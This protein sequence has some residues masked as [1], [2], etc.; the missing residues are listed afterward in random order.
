MEKPELVS[1]LENFADPEQLS[2]DLYF[3]FKTG[4]IYTQYSTQPNERL[5]NEIIE[6]FSKEIARYTDADNPYELYDIYDDNEHE[7][8]HLSF[9]SLDKNEIASAVFQ[10]DK[11]RV[12][13][14]TAEVGKLSEIYAFIIELSDGNNAIRI[15][16][17]SMP[18]HA[19][20][21]NKF[22]NFF[23]GEDNN[24]ELI[25]SDA[26]YFD[27]SMDILQFGQSVVII[28][29]KTYEVRFGF[30]NELTERARTSFDALIATGI[31]SHSADIQSKVEKLQKGEKK[32]LNNLMQNNLIMQ[33]PNHKA[34]ILRH[35]KKYVKHE[36]KIDEDGNIA[37]SSQR[38][39]KILIK[40]LNRDY[41]Q[42][43]I[44]RE[45]FDTN[46]KKLLRD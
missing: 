33:K 32:K 31:F 36:F 1:Y 15:Y 7:E 2:V 23:T 9:D 6:T 25:K 14:Y 5:R 38:D 41:N 37:L 3:V 44:T 26:I 39:L 17:Q 12:E 10:F 45:K 13:P 43:E 34:L 20:N 11:A 40:V 30:I 27:R 16:K 18:T 46:N 24:L 35:A 42:H 21:S 22:I 4:T 28:S 8:F 29:K 19:V